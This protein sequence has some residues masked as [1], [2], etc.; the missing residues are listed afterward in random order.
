MLVDFI[1]VVVRPFYVLASAFGKDANMASLG[2]TTGGAGSLQTVKDGKCRPVTQQ[3]SSITRNI[4]RSKIWHRFFR[5]T[6]HKK[7]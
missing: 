5:L 3:L 4:S 1:I 2:A 7:P 6:E